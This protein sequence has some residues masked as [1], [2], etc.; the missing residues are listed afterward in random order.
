M[1]HTNRDGG[2]AQVLRIAFPLI[3]ASSGHAFRLF[4]DRVMLA[5]YSQPAIAAAMPA[6]LTCFCLMCFFIGTAG[7]AGTF[8]AQYEGAG[9]RERTGL[10][11]WQGLYIALA[12][13]LFV[14]LCAPA[15]RW[16]FGWMGHGPEVLEQQI[17]Y[18][19]VL[20]RL[21]FGSILLAA[22]NGFWSGRGKTHVVMFIELLCAGTNIVLNY[23]LIFG[24]WGFPELGIEG[25]GYATGLSSI[26]G[27]AV[28]L[29]L[30]F[31]PQARARFG[32]FPARTFDA[33]LFRRLLRFGSPSGTQ[34]AL[35]LIA[36][37]LFVILLG[38]LGATELEAANVAFAVNAM[39]F[40][41]L[42]GLGMTVTILVGQAVGSG[43]PGQARRSVHSALVLAFIYNIAMG[44]CMVL[45]PDLILSIFARGGDAAQQHALVQAAVYM[46]FITAY[47]VFDGLYIIFSHAVRGAGDTR[48]AMAIGLVLSWGTL[49]LPSA[50][51]DHLQ[52][53]ATIRW[54]ILVVHVMLAA[55]VFFLRYR[56]GKWTRMRVIEEV[57]VF[58]IELQA[59]HGI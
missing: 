45:F 21:S 56:G 2:I 10:A 46:R 44:L 55:L 17:V 41:P 4:A 40:L 5:R 51:A 39:V 25:A 18:F 50:I 12:G 29:A 19:Q 42:I 35:D 20:A 13:G 59:D 28:A 33:A 3:M 49:V 31:A 58:E 32:T 22:I 14:A 26:L 36:F 11:V 23:A 16:I 8:V 54:L 15:A 43:R 1:Q 37:N 38:R 30:F 24:H 34:F 7:Y 47:L 9:R 57:P 48:F 53:S 27:L 52:A 6:G